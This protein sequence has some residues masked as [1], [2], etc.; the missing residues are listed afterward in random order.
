MLPIFQSMLNLF[1]YIKVRNKLDVEESKVVQV[2]F[3]LASEL[4][5]LLFS[6]LQFSEG[7]VAVLLFTQEYR[8]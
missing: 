1:L 4:I 5:K 2:L 7:L 3:G 6:N 8:V